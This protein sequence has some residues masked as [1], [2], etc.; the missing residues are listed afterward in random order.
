VRQLTG[1]ESQKPVESE[2]REKPLRDAEAL[3]KAGKPAD[4]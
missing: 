1:P 2:A 4:S 3:M